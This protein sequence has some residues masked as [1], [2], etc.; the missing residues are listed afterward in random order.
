MKEF[1]INEYITLKLEEGTTY[2]YIQDEKIKHSMGLFLNKGQKIKPNYESINLIDDAVLGL[3]SY[4]DIYNFDKLMISERERYH[5]GKKIY[6]IS[7][8]N[9][10][11]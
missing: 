2:I 11:D 7:A 1:K 5:P 4:V 9:F 6:N 3:V 8:D 10:V